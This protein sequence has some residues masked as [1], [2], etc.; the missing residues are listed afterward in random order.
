[1]QN[2]GISNEVKSKVNVISGAYT[3]PLIDKLFSAKQNA[4]D[5]ND[6][7]VALVA[8]MDIGRITE[9]FHMIRGLFGIAG[10]E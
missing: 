9:A 2:A 5:M 1:M 10:M 6:I 4:S 7:Y 3:L 8:L